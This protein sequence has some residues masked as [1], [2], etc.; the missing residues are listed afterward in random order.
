M[1]T[2]G[3]PSHVARS[4]AI[5][6]DDLRLDLT[7]TAG[8]SSRS[9]LP[10]QRAMQRVLPLARGLLHRLAPGFQGLHLHQRP[11][12]FLFV[13]SHRQ[14]DDDHDQPVQ[15]V[16]DDRAIRGRVCPA[17]DGVENAPSSAAIKLWIAAVDVPHALLN[18]IGSW[19]GSG[20]G[21]VASG[22]PAPGMHLEGPD[23]LG[24]EACAMS[25]LAQ[26]NAP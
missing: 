15:V 5:P 1:R 22:D 17:E 13:E 20:L 8:S 10:P 21:R 25:D 14:E 6:E 16:G 19:A 3:H 2:V 12:S 4:N 11:V 24:E 7:N 23:G 26:E 9:V 18:V